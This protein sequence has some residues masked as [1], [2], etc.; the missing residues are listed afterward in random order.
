MSICTSLPSIHERQPN[1]IEKLTGNK[2][3]VVLEV[4][5][6]NPVGHIS[7]CKGFIQAKLATKL[8]RKLLFCDKYA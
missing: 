1:S 3:I 6:Y 5:F 8:L 7:G 4:A 2:I